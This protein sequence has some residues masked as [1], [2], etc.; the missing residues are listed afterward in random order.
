MLSDSTRSSLLA[1]LRDPADQ[2]AWREFQATY[3]ELI[4]RFCRGR[5]LGHADAED[6]C[7]AV[8]I[9]LARSL[10]GFAYAR[11][12]GRFRNFL[13]KVVRNEVIR[14]M[15]RPENNGSRKQRARSAVISAQEEETADN[16]W[17][18]EWM[19]HHLRMAIDHVR[20]NSHERAVAMFEQILAGQS[21]DQIATAFETSTEAVYKVK[22]RMRDRI[23]AQVAAQIAE[24]DAPDG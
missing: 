2:D 21:V 1:R 10:P 23:K 16:V 18:Q 24:E 7:Q 6:V 20:E 12:R 9:R 11:E 8:M 4:I 3:R 14:H 13:G 17:E 22:Q 15:G 19:H 5:G